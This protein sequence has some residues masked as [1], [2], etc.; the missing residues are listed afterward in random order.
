MAVARFNQLTGKLGLLLSVKALGRRAAG[1][2]VESEAHPLLQ[3]AQQVIEVGRLVAV[4]DVDS[5][6][7]HA[8]RL[9]DLDLQIA[10]TTGRRHV[11]CGR[12]ARVIA[13]PGGDPQDELRGQGEPILYP[14]VAPHLYDVRPDASPFDAFLDLSDEELRDLVEVGVPEDA[15]NV[16]PEPRCRDDVDLGALRDVF[17]QQD[18]P[19]QAQRSDIYERPA[20]LVRLPQR[21]HR[22]V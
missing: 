7:V 1:I 18:I 11:S 3:D 16:E 13:G 6:Q 19:S 22:P 14:V 4:A 20:A 10:G 12:D 8:F 17:E 5:A 21:L 2:D 9:E 15:G